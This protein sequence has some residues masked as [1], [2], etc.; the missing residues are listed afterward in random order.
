M[1]CM[2]QRKALCELLL[3]PH[4]S[5]ALTPPDGIQRSTKGTRALAGDLVP[6]PI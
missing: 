6:P 1:P 2:A 4:C 5:H 3:L